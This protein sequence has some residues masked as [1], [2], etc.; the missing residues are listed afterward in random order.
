MSAFHRIVYRCEEEFGKKLLEKFPRRVRNCDEYLAILPAEARKGKAAWCVTYEFA[1]GANISGME[2]LQID[3]ENSVFP[4]KVQDEIYSNED[5]KQK[6]RLELA[7]GSIP[8]FIAAK[9]YGKDPCWVRAGLVCGWLLPI[10]NATRKG[11]LVTTIEEMNGR[12]GRI[13]YY[14][15]PRLLYEQTGYAWHG[16]R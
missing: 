14:I 8:V 11:K 15:S 12:C 13:N 7:T 3:P 16:E 2:I 9:V 6:S 10:G 5:D 1:D 4:I